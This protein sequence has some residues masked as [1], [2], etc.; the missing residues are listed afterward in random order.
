MPVHLLRSLLVS[1]LA[2]LLLATSG[3]AQSTA[4]PGAIRGK[5]VDARG[6]PLAESTIVDTSG[7]KL[8]TTGADGSF[9]IRAGTSEIE[10]SNPHFA[11][12]KVAMYQQLPAGSLML[13]VRSPQSRST[14]ASSDSAP[15]FSAS[16]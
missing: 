13:A 7:K 8:A 2:A 15:L 12:L 11:P 14:G 10:V 1:L 3:R 6:A 16:R 9:E 4:E 5:V